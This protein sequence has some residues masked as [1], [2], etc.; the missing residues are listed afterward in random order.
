MN[1]SKWVGFSVTLW[2]IF[3]AA[4]GV[5]SDQAAALKTVLG[6]EWAHYIDIGVIVCGFIL[7]VAGRFRASKGLTMLPML[8]MGLLV[9][10][11]AGLG[12]CSSSAGQA[13]RQAF[14]AP[15]VVAAWPAVRSDAEAGIAAQEAS[16]AI[17][18]GPAESKRE[19]LRQ[20]DS[21]VRSLGGGQ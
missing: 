20:F 8:A 21:A 14:L 4:A 12:G 19:R 13:A 10:G 3:L 15:A 16:G 9:V 1:E 7:A 6:P 17:G 2:G 5:L 18:P 11:M